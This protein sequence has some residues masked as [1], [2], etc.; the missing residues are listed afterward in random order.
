MYRSRLPIILI[1]RQYLRFSMRN[2]VKIRQDEFAQFL[3]RDQRIE[4]RSESICLVS[5][6]ERR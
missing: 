5:E 1:F 2:N 4:V 6:R 3:T